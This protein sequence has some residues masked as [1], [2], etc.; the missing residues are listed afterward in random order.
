MI[1]S[2]PR[3]GEVWGSDLMARSLEEVQRL[4][5][6]WVAIHPYAGVRRDGTVRSRTAFGSGYLERAV[7]LAD[8]AGVR[9][10]WK[11]HLAYWGSFTWR[12]DIDFGDDEEAWHRFFAGYSQF[13]VDQAR[14]AQRAGVELFAVGVEVEK[15]TRYETEWRHLIA[16]VRQ[17]FS[18]E[19]TYAANWDTLDRV[20]FWDAVD[21]IGVHAYFPLAEE[22][23]P[24]RESLRRGWDRPLA[25][26][27]ELSSRF[28]KPVLVA[29]VGYNRSPD[30]ARAPWEHTIRNSV[31]SRTLRQRLIEVALE[32]LEATPFI[33]G[34]FWWKWMPGDPRHDRNFSMKDPEAREALRRYWGN[35]ST[36]PPDVG[37]LQ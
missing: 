6:T 16:A 32:R 10:F 35:V 23:D 11:P 5:V 26:L 21:L 31:Q 8:R 22:N 29:E 30:A 15:T 4:G 25:Q 27:E 34:M 13:I 9:L 37:T 33:R 7:E 36:R 14:F 2:C 18:G 19:I 1:I 28:R 20:P 24:G 17:V 3:W 12:G